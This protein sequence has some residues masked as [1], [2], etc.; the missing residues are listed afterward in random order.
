M[1]ISCINISTGTEDFVELYIQ[2][3][4]HGCVHRESVSKTVQKICDF[5]QFLFPDSDSP[6][7]AEGS[8]RFGQCQML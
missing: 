3:Y 2:F 5:V 1:E 4:V 8:I 7:T 6:T